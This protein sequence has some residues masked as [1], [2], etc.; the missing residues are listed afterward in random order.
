MKTRHVLALV[1]L[2]LVVAGVGGYFVSRPTAPPAAPAPVVHDYDKYDYGRGD[3]AKVIDIGAQPLSINDSLFVESLF[4]DRILQQQ[5]NAEGWKLR[6]HGF[7]SGGDMRPYIDGRLDFMI[8]GDV[9]AIISMQKQLVGTYML[10]TAGNVLVIARNKKTVSE[11]KGLRVGYPPKT[12]AHFGL[13]RSL[14]TANLTMDDIVS[15]PLKANELAAALLDNKVDAV[16]I[17]DTI[18]VKIL[19]DVPGSSV[20]YSADSYSY[21]VADKDFASRHPQL[22]RAVLAA[23]FRATHW[24][25]LEEEHTRSMLVWV[26]QTQIEYAGKSSF[27]VNEK[28]IKFIR[29]D[30]LR[31][32]SFPLLPLD[33]RDE[34]KG[35]MFKRFEFLKRNGILPANAEW[36]KVS[37][38][39]DTA[40]LPEIIREGEKW[41]I[42]RFDYA[43]D[44]LYR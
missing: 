32:P 16:A 23:F 40:L 27:E 29:D 8:L 6:W 4:H 44:R 38:R 25:K 28:W 12:T 34:Q 31:F 2:L 20:V 36:G 42:T 13:E 10:H 21:V 43:P 18:A 22:L 15:I 5:L 1:L 14:L 33:I 17:W 39:T 19:A 24:G 26:R 35:S 30:A 7:T 37:E 9:P 3:E 11:L 41:R